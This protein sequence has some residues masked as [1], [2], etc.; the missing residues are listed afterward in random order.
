[1]SVNIPR[2]RATTPSWAIRTTSAPTSRPSRTPRRF[3]LRSSSKAAAA[4][5]RRWRK[6]RRNLEVLQDHRQH[7]PTETAHFQTWHDKAGNAPAVTDGDLVFPDLEAGK[8]AIGRAVQEEPDHARAVRLPEP[9]AAEMLHRSADGDGAHRDERRA[10]RSRATACSSV[11]RRSSSRPCAP[12][13]RR[14]TRPGDWDRTECQRGVC[15]EILCIIGV[16]S[17]AA[18]RVRWVPRTIPHRG[19][20]PK[21][22]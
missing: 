9:V 5:T 6:R 7:R 2:F 14:P 19:E 8:F 21:W 22:S 11:S 12:S 1:M 17:H 15:D 10:W 4:S 16:S 3:T 18:T 20:V 13:P